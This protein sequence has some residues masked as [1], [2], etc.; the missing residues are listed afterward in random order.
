MFLVIQAAQFYI[1]M[2]R[3]FQQDKINHYL[4]R[5]EQA[6]GH[7]ADAYSR[8]TVKQVCLSSGPVQQILLLQLQLPIW[9]QSQW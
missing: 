7:M 4:V 3:L 5:H 1:S 9:T 2:T 8:V 6:A